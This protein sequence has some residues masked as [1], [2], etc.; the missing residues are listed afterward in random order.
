MILKNFIVFEGIDGAGTSTQ[1][2]ILQKR[3]DAERFFFT[4]EPTDSE[5]GKFLRKMLKGDV[6]LDPRTSAFLFAADR[7]EHLYGKGGTN[8]GVIEQ[9]QKG[10]IVVSDRYLFSSLTYQSVTCGDELPRR[11]NESFPLPEI[12]F[13]FD[14]NPEISLKRVLGRGETEIYEKLDFQKATAERYRAVIDEYEKM[15]TG[16]KIV[17][18]DASQPVEKVADLI[19]QHILPI[20]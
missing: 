19:N 8:C 15:N 3:K 11:L 2:K 18:L 14:I 4:T 1:I 6:E 12:L 20:L 13:F 17:H 16:M 9:A 7:N 10:K 5:T